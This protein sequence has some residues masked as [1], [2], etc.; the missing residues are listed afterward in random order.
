ME[1]QYSSLE[2]MAN[3]TGMPD[4]DESLREYVIYAES[5]FDSTVIKVRLA[6]VA[7]S[8]KRYEMIISLLLYPQY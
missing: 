3:D 8:D 2:V 1:K 7:S 4:P 5:D 6:L